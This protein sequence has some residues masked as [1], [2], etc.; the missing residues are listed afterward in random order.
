M[1]RLAREIIEYAWDTKRV[2]YFFAL[3]ATKFERKTPD[4]KQ[5]LTNLKLWRYEEK[6]SGCCKPLLCKIKFK[7]MINN[8]KIKENQVQDI[9]VTVPKGAK[10]LSD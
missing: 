2:S 7:F 1:K 3:I 5:V 6:M 4:R 10:H 8:D 9:E